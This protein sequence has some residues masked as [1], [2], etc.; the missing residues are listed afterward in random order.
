MNI[1]ETLQYILPVFVLVYLIKCNKRRSDRYP[2]E[3]SFQEMGILRVFSPHIRVIPVEIQL[4]S[5]KLMKPLLHQGGLS[6]L[7]R[8]GEKYHLSGINLRIE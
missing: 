8:A 2:G 1:I 6:D 3:M 5:T 7:P 4:I